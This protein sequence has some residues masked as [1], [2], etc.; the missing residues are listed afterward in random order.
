MKP[1]LIPPF[2]FAYV[3]KDLFRGS[4]PVALNFD[5]LR[6]LHLKTIVSLIPNPI[7]PDLKKFCEDENI[8]NHTYI[9]P[10]FTDQIVMTSTTI[11]EIINIMCDK[12]NFPLYI[13]STNGAH[14]TGLV[15][16]CLR[17]LQM[18]SINATLNEFN[19]F[20]DSPESCEEEFVNNFKATFEL[21][22]NRPAWLQHLAGKKSHPTLRVLIIG[23]E[24]TDDDED[25]MYSDDDQA[26][27]QV[28]KT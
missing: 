5:F 11:T 19:Q 10:K 12:Q 20:V 1:R 14:N 22:Q 4:Y 3:E 8:T 17:K 6:T 7:D 25:D 23:E 13:H 28:S 24:S 26:D 9:V 18:W 27:K 16:M 21:S 15:I 2:R